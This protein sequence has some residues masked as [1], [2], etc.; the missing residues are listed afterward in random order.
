[1][2][3]V[4]RYN[5]DWFPHYCVH[6]MTM[7]IIENKYELKG[8]AFWFKLLEM[9]G[10]ANG[11]YIDFNKD[12][13]WEFLQAKTRTSKEECTDIL[14]TLAKLDAIDK[15]LWENKVVWSDNFIE[16]IREAYR[17]RI[18]EIPMKPT[19]YNALNPIKSDNLRN[20]TQETQNITQD[21]HNITQEKRNVT[22]ALS[23]SL[24]TSLNKDNIYT[25]KREESITDIERNITQDNGLNRIKSVDL[26]RDNNKK[27]Y[28]KSVHLTTIEH[29]KLVE[30]FGEKET[31]D[32]IESLSLYK[33]SKGKKYASDYATILNW[34]R[35]DEKE[36]NTPVMPKKRFEPGVPDD[37]D[38]LLKAHVDKIHKGQGE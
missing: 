3:R 4:P 15:E 28:S 10:S 20:I 17:T 22:E 1:M 7:Q 11:H 21:K 29:D 5:V 24:N 32:K 6:K 13:A 14:D 36:K 37:Y 31:K 19:V 30:K 34:D 12:S 33:L 16:G 26:H 8:Y 23:S 25:N 18:N 9:L 2:P 35:R 27:E 38:E